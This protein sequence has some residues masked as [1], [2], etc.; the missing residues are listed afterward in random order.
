MRKNPTYTH[1][2]GTRRLLILSKYSHLYYHSDPLSIRNSRVHLSCST[3]IS[4]HFF[5][6]CMAIFH[7]AEV[8]TVILRCLMGLNLEFWKNNSCLSSDVSK[9][10]SV[11]NKLNLSLKYW[12]IEAKLVFLHVMVPTIIKMSSRYNTDY[13]WWGQ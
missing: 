8:Q 5:D 13:I 6:I 11:W 2:F 10:T 3:T 12:C 1:L 9:L 4:G 7:R